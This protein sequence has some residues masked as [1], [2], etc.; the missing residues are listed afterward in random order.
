MKTGILT[1]HDG[2]NYGAF[3]QVYSLQ[4]HLLS[5]GLDVQVINYKS[6][7]FT[8]RERQCFVLPCDP[9]A[10]ARNLKKIALFEQ[11]HEKLHVTERLF[12]EEEL[13]AHRFDRV[14]VGSDEVWN[15]STELIGFDPVYF[16]QGVVAGKIIS[17]APSFGSVMAGEPIPAEVRVNL[18]RLGAVSVRDE[19]SARIMRGITGKPA[20]VVLDPT[21]LTDLSDQAV[22]PDGE[23]YILVYGFFEPSMVRSIREHARRTGKRTVSL[24]YRL[25]WC[26]EIRDAVTPFEWLGYF[27]NCDCVVTT[28]FHG[29][30]FSILNRK[31]FCMF[32]TDYRRNKIG[33][34]LEDTGLARLAVAGDGDLRDALEAAVDYDEAFRVID[35]KRSFSRRYLREAL[36]L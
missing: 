32:V 33:T 34:L 7:G 2:I 30:I 26:D 6:P 1:F 16:T 10:T 29:M 20:P 15:F 14:V 4:S 5:L 25:E 28:M 8:E 19:N 18:Q 22:R 35:E 9:A 3:C 23:G 31:R 36:E 27:Q 12:H 24:G 11:A 21:F 13:S 17:Y